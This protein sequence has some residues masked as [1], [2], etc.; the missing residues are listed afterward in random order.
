M[1]SLTARRVS[2]FAA[3]GLL[4]VAGC[5]SHPSYPKARLKASLQDL[6]Q[7]EGLNVS[8]RFID[9]TIAVK[10]EHPGAIVAASN[11]VEPGPGFD[12]AVRKSLTILHRVLLSTD[13][14]VRF[15][16]LLLAD[17]TVQGAYLTLVRYMDDIRRANANMLDTPEMFA[18]TILEP[19][20]LGPEPLT[21]ERYVPRDIQLEEFLSWQL[22]RRIQYALAQELQAQ[23]L[24]D[25]GRC[26]GEFRNGEFAFTLD[27]APPINRTLDDATM[28]HA[29]AA[30]TQVISKVLSSY[31]FDKFTAVRLIHPSTGRNVVLPKASL[32]LL[33]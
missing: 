26:A 13:A 16:V 18:R 31:Q 22:A 25:V 12:E 28:Q 29:F 8:V 30:S 20:V 10:V 7:E 11:Q 21:I 27:I 4:W 9:H 23:G 6:F 19:Y 3:I 15:Y 14:D 33:R 24:A 32:Q 17:P 1:R 2:A 5:G